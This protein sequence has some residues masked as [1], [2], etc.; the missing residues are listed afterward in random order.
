ME[1]I[2]EYKYDNIK[3]IL[4]VLVV[5]GHLLENVNTGILYKTIYLF[6]MAAFVFVS[7]YFTKCSQ[8]SI[9]KKVAIYAVWQTIYY[10]IYTYFLKEK[11]EYNCFKRPIW[12]MWYLYALIVWELIILLIPEKVREKINPYVMIIISIFLALISGFY[13]KIGYDYSLAKIISFFPFFLIGYFQKNR[14]INILKLEEKSAKNVYKTI[15]FLIIF[16]I[17]IIYF[18]FNLSSKNERCLYGAFSY[19]SMNYSMLFKSMWMAFGI[20]SIF[21]LINTIPDK[22]IKFI[23]TIGSNTLS[24]YLMHGIIMKILAKYKSVI[25]ANSYIIN[26]LIITAMTIVIVGVFGNNIA[27]GILSLDTYKKIIEGKKSE[28]HN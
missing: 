12:I 11:I 27:K 4:I 17:T 24:I 9:I 10:L 18:V 23:S 6:H 2:R 14:N 25:F 1:K 16:I 13:E 7:G 5:F 3:F 20:C 15:L 19:K 28:K 8:K 26:I 21:I 22:K